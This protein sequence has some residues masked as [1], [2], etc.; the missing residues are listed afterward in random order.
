MTGVVIN[1][2]VTNAKFAKFV[3]SQVRE[4]QKKNPEPWTIAENCGF[5][6]ALF[7]G[8]PESVVFVNCPD[9]DQYFDY[10]VHMSVFEFLVKNDLTLT[11][12]H[13]LAYID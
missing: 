13:N 4:L 7:D 3:S 2:E 5:Q 8:T 6:E 11:T 9:K 12:L 1:D 10:K